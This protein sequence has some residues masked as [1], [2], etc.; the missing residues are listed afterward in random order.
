M[1]APHAEVRTVDLPAR[2][3]V[4]FGAPEYVEID[5]RFGRIAFKTEHAIEMPLGLPGFPGR[6]SFGLSA[7]PSD[8]FDQ[9]LLFQDLDDAKLCFLVLPM[10]ISTPLIEA[11]D[12]TEALETLGVA[13]ESAAILLIVTVRQ[14]QGGAAATV[15]LRAPI[16]L[17]TARRTARQH[18]MPNSKY[19][20]RHAI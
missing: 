18:V 1:M 15:N 12:V 6:R 20:I 11:E 7:V 13:H 5:T 3:P 9:F 4:E 17:D 8:K 19:A 2:P 16:I 14:D 10:P